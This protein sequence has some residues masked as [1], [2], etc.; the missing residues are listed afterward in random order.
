LRQRDLA[1]A[2]GISRQYLSDLEHGKCNISPPVAKRLADV[3]GLTIDDIITF[4]VHSHSPTKKIG[5]GETSKT[6]A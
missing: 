4:D 6:G 2:A 5:H 3:L 1:D